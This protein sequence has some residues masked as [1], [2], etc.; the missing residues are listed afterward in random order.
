MRL[1]KE[2]KY[3]YAY[4]HAGKRGTVKV[5]TRCTNRED[6]LEVVRLSRLK[7][8]EL[9][10]RAG[11]LTTQAVNLILRGSNKSTLE[12][13]VAEHGTWMESVKLS[14]ATRHKRLSFLAHFMKFGGH[15]DK[16]PDEITALD[17]SQFINRP[18]DVKASSRQFALSQLCVFFD[19]LRNKSF[20]TENPAR[21]T[22]VDMGSLSHEQKEPLTKEPFTDEE[23]NCL[24]EQTRKLDDQFWYSAILIGRHTALRL[25]DICCLE[26]AS[27]KEKLVV[28]TGKTDA[29]VSLD[30]FLGVRQMLDNMEREDGKWVFPRARLT[31]KKPETRSLISMQFRRL[32]DKCG[33]KKSFHCLRHQRATEI[34]NES[35]LKEAGRQLGH[36]NESTTKIYVH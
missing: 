31:Y 32:C 26:W 21:L 18:G 30:L 2:G 14:P 33:I 16:S 4:Y 15:K 19:W 24:L 12:A 11:V 29:R 6:A 23:V 5:S 7:E 27:V 22:R 20:V 9:A 1:V 8:I 10:S 34:H 17:V 13:L 3:F 28:W 35:G 36:S 25:G